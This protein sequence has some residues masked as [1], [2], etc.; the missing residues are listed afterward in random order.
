M[1]WVQEFLRYQKFEKRCSP[2]TLRAYGA[3][4]Q[5]VQSFRNLTF[6]I[7]TPLSESNYHELRAWVVSL[8]QSRQSPASVNRRISTIKSYFSFLRRRELRVDNPAT[9]IKR[10]KSARPLP[11][12]VP[13]TDMQ[14][15]LDQGAAAAETSFG[16]CRDH[17]LLSLLYGTGMR[18]AELLRLRLDDVNFATGQVRVLGKR[19]RV[20]LIP[21]P[22][23]VCAELGD[24]ILQ[25]KNV[26]QDTELD[27]LF[28]NDRGMP[29][30]E[31]YLYRCVRRILSQVKAL[32]RRSPH[33]LRH[34]YA[35][36]LLDQGAGL[37][38]VKELLGHT[39]LAATQVYTH[40]SIEKLKEVYRAAHPHSGKN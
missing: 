37:Q 15:L 5:A 12:M 26:V 23:V 24:F 40:R 18:R 29:I 33:V 39:S 1:D 31:S 9:R 20:R 34:T 28:V 38:D 6:N 2:H 13:L 21:L 30:S 4:L 36:H 19:N 11:P 22:T 7:Q 25:R 16:A 35:T 8:L 3:D 27:A 10:P 17:L 14:K 32:P